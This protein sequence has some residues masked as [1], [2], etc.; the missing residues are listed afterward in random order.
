MF[1][2]LACLPLAAVL[3]NDVRIESSSGAMTV[4][5]ATS[6]PVDRADVRG[7]SGGSRRMFV[8]LQG[9]QAERRSF[10]T[11]PESVLVHPRARY[12]KLE[13]PTDGRCAAQEVGA[14]GHRG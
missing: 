14:D 6:E 12:T 13:I 1:F 9:T 3:I 11:G 4:D 10:G 7:V 5:V 2:H 8:Y